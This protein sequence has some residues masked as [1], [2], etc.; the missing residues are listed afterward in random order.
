MVRPAGPPARADMFRAL[1][2]ATPLADARRQARRLLAGE[3][4]S[5]SGITFDD[6]LYDFQTLHCSQKRARTRHD[7]LRIISK[8]Y[9]PEL[10]G[11]R[12]SAITHRAVADI[13]DRLIGTPSERSHCFGGGPHLLPVLRAETIHNCLATRRYTASEI[14]TPCSTAYR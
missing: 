8:H 13:T 9:A 7:Y 2:P 12:L 6:A 4:E 11:K 14:H 3:P 1:P 5:T 10:T